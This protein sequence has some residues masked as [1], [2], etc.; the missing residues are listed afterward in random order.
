[1]QYTKWQ[2]HRTIIRIVSA[3]LLAGFLPADLHMQMQSAS[4]DTQTN[5]LWSSLPKLIYSDSGNLSKIEDLVVDGINYD[6]TFKYDSFLNV[7]GSPNGSDFNRPTFW[8]NSQTAKKAVD[9]IASLLNSQQLVPT[10]LNNQL[11]ALIPYRGVVAPNGSLFLVSKVNSY[12]TNWVNFR[13]ES[14]DIFTRG[15]EVANYAIF[16]VQNPK[17]VDTQAYSLWSSSPNSISPTIPIDPD[18]EPVE[19]GM[20]FT[21]N[22]PGKISAIQFYRTVPIDS[23]YLINLWDEQGNLL[24]NAVSIEGHQTTPGWQTVQ[25]YPPVAIEA[26]KTYIA[27]YYANNGRYPVNEN[28]FQPKDDTNAAVDDNSFSVS[29]GPLYALCDRELADGEYKCRNGVYKYGL[30]GFPTETY[31][32]SNYWVDVIFKPD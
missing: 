4:A 11:S 30:S 7:F 15:N 26:G 2:N 28:F 19:L 27:S 14:Q 32:S 10:K 31:K 29:N 5:S 13:G 3:I 6:V 12:I 9:N 17:T 18:T 21:T 25:L 22:V 16:T 20:K 8:D 23:S 24:G 1:M